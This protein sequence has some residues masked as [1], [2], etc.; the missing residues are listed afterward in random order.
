MERNRMVLYYCQ[1]YRYVVFL[2]W[3]I[4]ESGG[5]DYIDGG[6]SVGI[7]E[8]PGYLPWYVRGEVPV[9]YPVQPVNHRDI[10]CISILEQ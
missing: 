4:E 6:G 7:P 9:I 1:A 2:Q 10:Q 8:V 3:D 5:W